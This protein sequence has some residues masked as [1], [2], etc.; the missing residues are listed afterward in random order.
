MMEEP[1]LNYAFECVL[2]GGVTA[3]YAVPA[4]SESSAR[5]YLRQIK[6]V[7][8]ARLVGV[9]RECP[10]WPRRDSSSF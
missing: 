7:R 3:F 8:R 10:P 2:P 4:R 9:W 1:R 5:R 6:H